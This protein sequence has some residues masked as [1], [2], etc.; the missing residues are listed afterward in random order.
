VRKALFFNDSRTPINRT[1]ADIYVNFRVVKWKVSG[2]NCFLL[3]A[4]VGPSTRSFPARLQGVYCGT[5]RACMVAIKAVLAVGA[6]DKT[7]SQFRRS[8][9]FLQRLRLANPDLQHGVQ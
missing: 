1:L 2:A 3:S 9:R 6:Q 4:N 8:D 5:S 7:S